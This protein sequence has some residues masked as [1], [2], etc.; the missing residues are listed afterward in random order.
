MA[1][2]PST[3]LRAFLIILAA[4]CGADNK[5]EPN[6]VVLRNYSCRDCR[7]VADSVAFIGHPDDTVLVSQFNIPAV[8][9]RGRLYLPARDADRIQVFNPSGRLMQ[10]FGKPG[11]G[12]GEFD[13]V[14]GVGPSAG[15]TLL[16]FANNALHVVSPEYVHVRQFQTGGDGSPLPEVL[17]DG[18]I[19]ITGT[20]NMFVRLS[21]T[22][23]TLSRVAL[24]GTDST[25]KC[26]DCVRRR[27]A[28]ARDGGA[29]W[30]TT[31]DRYVV[32]LHSLDGDLQQRFVR[33]ADWFTPWPAVDGGGAP[34][35]RVLVEEIA[36]FFAK[37]RMF[38]V[39]EDDSG[40]LW[41]Y[42]MFVEDLDGLKKMPPITDPDQMS[43]L[44]SRLSLRVEAIDLASRMVLAGT[45]FKTIGSPIG[46][47]LT[48][49]L[50]AE[51]TGDAMWKIVRLRVA[52]R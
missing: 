50:F 49:F 25:R 38:G 30:S 35:E 20:P 23:D 16:I 42:V 33:E 18:S 34:G 14:M 15:D 46:R 40:V 48:A 37:P 47:G 32:D 2:Y 27:Y 21:A 17:P 5:S 39:A 29:V 9:S 6:T 8:D 10:T 43:E 44:Y 52:N 12:P 3:I 19:I 24:K 1:R 36:A 4:A 11:Q 26:A 7:I 22:G 31:Q 41:T 13:G 45:T 28:A 51:P